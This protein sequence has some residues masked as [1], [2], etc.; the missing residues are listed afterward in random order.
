MK[1]AE[2]ARRFD[3][4][5][6]FAEIE[7][8]LDTPVKRYS[9]GMHVRL[10]FAVAAH[11]EPEILVVDE[12]LAVGDAQ[13][14]K[15]CFERLHRLKKSHRTILFVSHNMAAVRSICSRGV[16]LTEGCVVDEGEIDAV[17]DHYLSTAGQFADGAVSLDTLGFLVHRIEVVPGTGSVIKPFDPVSITV[18]F[19]PKF[20]VR[21]PGLY[22]GILT[23]EEERLAG[24]DLKDFGT[25]PPISAGQRARLGFKIASLPFVPGSYRLEIHLKDIA[26]HRIEKLPKNATFE[27]A[28][29]PV[30]GGRKLDQWFGSTVLKLD[31]LLITS[32]KGI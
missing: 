23:S 26:S 12:V 19:T 11:L 5:V 27:V 30:Y 15:K 7:K 18:E 16:V 31:G 10:A 9:S 13:F 4:I 17:V 3:E 25:S 6:D 24:L 29:V 8:F 1:R 22:V 2:I 32:Q 20:Q 28:E 21:D 14:Q